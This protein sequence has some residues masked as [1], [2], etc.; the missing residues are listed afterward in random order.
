VKTEDASQQ[1]RYCVVIANDDRSERATASLRPFA[2]N[3]R[4]AR[5]VKM[6]FLRQSSI[7]ARKLASPA[8]VVLSAQAADRSAWEGPFW[9]TRPSNRFVADHGAPTALAT[10][11]ALLSIAANAPSSLIAVM[12]SDF[13][14]GRE[15]ILTE[16]IDKVCRLLPI[17]PESVATLGIVDTHMEIDEDYLV[18]GPNNPHKGA[19]IQARVNRPDPRIA[20]QLINEGAMIASGILL[21]HARAFAARICKYWPPLAQELRDSQQ[22]HSRSEIEHTLVADTYRHIPKSVINSMRLSPPT[23]P[24]RAFRVQGSGWCSRKPIGHERAQ[25]G[26]CPCASPYELNR[27]S[28]D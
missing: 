6:G 24:M 3:A 10:A 20:R 27:V 17:I 2:P 13:W 5:L 12:P 25:P 1:T 18:V 23:F 21:G 14:V 9:F 22:L 15:A 11:A 8:N 28:T 16:A 7:R 4:Q 26:N 19:V